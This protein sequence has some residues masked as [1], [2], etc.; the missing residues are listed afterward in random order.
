MTV[1][2]TN[3]KGK[4]YYLHRGK[5]KTGKLRYYFSR[6]SEGT[7]ADAMPAGHEVYENPNGQVYVRRCDRTIAAGEVALVESW[8][9]RFSGVKY[10]KVDVKKRGIG[11]YTA[12]QD[13]DGLVEVLKRFPGPKEVTVD[14]VLDQLITY[15]PELRFVL[16]DKKKRLFVA[17]RYRERDWENEWVEISEPNSLENLLGKHVKHLGRGSL[18]GFY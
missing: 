5:T 7:L 6:R 9:K 2:Y 12:R 15:S 3:R 4:V 1:E 18:L 14:V 8:V 16:V 17:Q 13:V 11:V 10:F